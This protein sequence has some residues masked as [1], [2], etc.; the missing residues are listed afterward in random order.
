MWDV[1]DQYVKV[2]SARLIELIKDDINAINNVYLYKNHSLVLT[3]DANASQSDVLKFANIIKQKVFNT[4]NI[5]L[6]IEPM[7]ISN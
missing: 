7:V 6:E 5:S 2:G 4:F 3:T 1:D